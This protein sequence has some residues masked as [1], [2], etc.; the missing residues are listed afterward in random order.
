MNTRKVMVWTIMAVVAALV[1]PAWVSAAETRIAYVDLQRAL[2][3]CRAGKDAKDKIKRKYD[4]YE[5]EFSSRQRELKSMKEELERGGRVLSDT[6]RTDKER[7]YQQKIK[8]FQRFTKDAQDV[9][10]QQDND[11]TR[12]IVSELLALVRDMG[13]K[14][15][16][17]LIMERGEGSIV[18]GAPELDLTD[19]LIRL[20]DQKAVKR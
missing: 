8:D 12:T 17:T 16:Y 1:T 18:Y 9:I 3:Q 13:K 2:N 11:Y 5:R 7:R 4:G 6:A 19:Q 15:N 20:H 14:G 10:K